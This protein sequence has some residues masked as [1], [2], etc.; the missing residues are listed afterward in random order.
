MIFKFAVKIHLVLRLT[1][2]I[3][4]GSN[5]SNQFAITVFLVSSGSAFSSGSVFQCSKLIASLKYIYLFINQHLVTWKEGCFLYFNI[6]QFKFLFSYPQ[7]I[8]YLKVVW[9]TYQV[10]CFNSSFL[11]VPIMVKY[12]FSFTRKIIYLFS[13]FMV[14]ILF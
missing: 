3:L 8:L 5:L 14:L 6:I 12:I 9:K 11:A 1:L 2:Q 10:I 7:C 4:V 13:L